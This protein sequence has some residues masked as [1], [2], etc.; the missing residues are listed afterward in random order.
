MVSWDC[1]WCGASIES[2]FAACANDPSCPECC[3]TFIFEE[4]IRPSLAEA[5]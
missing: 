2:E 1:P 5:A 4:P 3:T